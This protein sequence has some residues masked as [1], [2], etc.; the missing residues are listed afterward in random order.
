SAPGIYSATLD[1]TDNSLILQSSTP[2]DKTSKL[3][4]LAAQTLSGKN[5]GD[6]QGN[7]ITSSTLA[8]DLAHSTTLAL[9]DNTDFPG[10]ITF[11]GQTV[12]SNSLILTRALLADANGSN[13]V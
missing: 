4:T 1:L 7:G 2:A 11:A 3:S 8:A 10:R 5:N 13:S 9:F 12:D 6:W